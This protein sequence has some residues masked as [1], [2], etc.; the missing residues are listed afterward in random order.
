MI[1]F[2]AFKQFGNFIFDMEFET[3]SDVTGLLGASGCGKSMTLNMIAGII[4]PDKGKIVLNGKVLFD[5]E[6]KINL[7]TKDRK[8]GFLFQNYALFP[9]MT[10]ED[11]IS[12]GLHTSRSEKA[13]EVKKALSFVRLE[14]FEKRYPMN[15]SGGQQQRVALARIIAYKPELLLLDEPFSALDEYLR[16][17]MVSQMIDTIGKLEL[18][19]LFVSH[20]RDEVFRLCDSIAIVEN[21]TIITFKSKQDTFDNP[22]SY[23]GMLLTGCKNISRT[24]KLSANLIY[25]L[26]WGTELKVDMKV[27]DKIK[28]VGIRAHN[29]KINSDVTINHL[30]CVIEKIYQEN[31]E[32]MLFIKNKSMPVPLIVKIPSAEGMKYKEG[33]EIYIGI[34]KSSILMAEK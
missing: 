1:Y 31:F 20:S 30:N 22:Q 27:P 6:K 7:K 24:K 14:G 29:I 28:Y 8:V 4:K 3:E 25:A 2:K 26:D 23:S 9:N 11:N 21:G 13:E 18:P 5:S 15:L 19:A 34:E 32:T 10:V 12:F 33:Q 16:T 17:Q